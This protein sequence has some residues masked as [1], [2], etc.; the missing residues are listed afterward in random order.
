R[1]TCLRRNYGSIIVRDDEIISTGYSGAP[2]GRMNCSDIGTCKR[3]ELNI[4]RGTQ[5]EKCRSV[6]SELNAIISASR[7][8]MLG[9]T[10]YLVGRDMKTGDLVKEADSCS[11]CKRAIINAGIEKIVIRDSHDDFRVVNVRKW[12]VEDES[13]TDKTGY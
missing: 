2:R 13:M 3:E 8:D 9:S 4:P 5:Y 6:H 10:L 1:G 12:I 11:M 7:S